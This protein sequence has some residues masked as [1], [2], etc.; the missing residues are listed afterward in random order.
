MVHGPDVETVIASTLT[1]EVDPTPIVR[2]GFECFMRV[3]GKV[4][5]S[6]KQNFTDFLKIKL[7]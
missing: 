4:F 6:R 3:I 5:F 1:V 7:K 2:Q